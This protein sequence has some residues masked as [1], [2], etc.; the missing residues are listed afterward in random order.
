MYKLRNAV[1]CR[2][3]LH[4]LKMKLAKYS[5]AGFDRGAPKWK[6][7]LW[8]L[9]RALFFMT[10]LPFPS[11][12]K[13]RLLRGFGAKIGKSVVIRSLVNISF[14]WRLSI[15]D[16]VWIGDGV[17]IL[18]LAPVTIESNVCLSQ[19]A[20]LCTGTHE[21]RK[22]TFDL[23]TQPIVIHEGSW[24]AANAFVGPGIEVGP[25]SVISAA[26]VVLQSVPART[27]VRGNP[28]VVVKQIS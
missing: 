27:I 13:T 23:I 1:V 19:R 3:Y 26:S 16:D 12:L 25:D 20:Y 22:E 24:V 10:P 6:E 7:A 9:L 14:P 28:A 2:I 8:V 4:K 21:Y 18:S 15:G 17:W 11:A 5:T